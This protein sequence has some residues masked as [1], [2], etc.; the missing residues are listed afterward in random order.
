MHPDYKL[1]QFGVGMGGKLL[2]SIVICC[3]TIILGLPC[4]Q[5]QIHP[6]Q[7]YLHQKS[8]LVTLVRTVHQTRRP[9]QPGQP[10]RV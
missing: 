10:A 1:L 7:A 8:H 4:K 3:I 2:E 5:H 9:A 6:A